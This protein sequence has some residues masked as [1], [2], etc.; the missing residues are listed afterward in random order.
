MTPSIPASAE[1]KRAQFGEARE[2]LHEI[3]QWIDTEEDVPLPHTD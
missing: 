3:A 2:A 1:V